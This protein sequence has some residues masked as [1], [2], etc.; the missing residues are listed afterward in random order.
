[1]AKISLFSHCTGSCVEW[2]ASV[3]ETLDLRGRWSKTRDGRRIGMR[4][5]P[6]PVGNRQSAPARVIARPELQFALLWRMDR[7]RLSSR[8]FAATLL[9]CCLLASA[10]QAT[11]AQAPARPA[12]G[13]HVSPAKSYDTLLT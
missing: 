7:M 5:Q 12:P 9:G 13:T 2:I 1:M 11:L 6:I 3:L 10:S 4:F 8:S